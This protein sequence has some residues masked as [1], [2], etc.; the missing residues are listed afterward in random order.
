MMNRDPQERL[1]HGRYVFEGV[2]NTDEGEEFFQNVRKYLNSRT[3]QRVVRRWRGPGNWWGS[4]PP[5]QADSFVI[6]IDE[7]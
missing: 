2:P 4:C 3:D 6:Y 1:L 5:S 7:R